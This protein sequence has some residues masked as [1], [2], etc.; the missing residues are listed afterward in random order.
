MSPFPHRSVRNGSIKAIIGDKDI[1]LH[2]IRFKKMYQ[3]EKIQKGDFNRW[4]Y[5]PLKEFKHALCKKET[6]SV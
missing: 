5:V 4:A 1:P 6:S 2:K 3:G